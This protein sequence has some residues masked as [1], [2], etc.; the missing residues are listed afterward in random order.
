MLRTKKI[1]DCCVHAY[2]QATSNTGI[3]VYTNTAQRKEIQLKKKHN[4]YM[5]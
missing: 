4:I 2:I 1:V 5:Y 3:I